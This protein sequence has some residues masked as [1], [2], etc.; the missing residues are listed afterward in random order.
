MRTGCSPGSLDGVTAEHLFHG[1]NTVLPMLLSDMFTICTRFGIVPDAF[2]CGTLVPILKK[3]NLDP[4]I[5]KKYRPITISTTLSKVLEYHILEQCDSHVYSPSQ[6]GFIPNGSTTMAAALAHDV[7]SYSVAS[8]S[9]VY[10]CS[11]DAAGAF[12]ALP[13]SI[14]FHRAIGV[15]PDSCWRVL[16]HW[17]K[18]MYVNI[19][20]GNILSDNIMVKRGTRQGG[21]TSSLLFNLFYQ[22]LI[23]ELQLCNTG[24]KI[25]AENY[26][27]YCYADDLLLSS[28]TVSGLQ[29]LINI[30]NANITRNALT[31]NP[32]KTECLLVGG[33]PF[34]E[35]PQWYMDGAS[36]NIVDK[37]T[38]LGT[39]LGDSKGQGQTTQR[40]QATNRAFITRCQP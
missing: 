34:T 37:I 19:K 32:Q 39:I 16:F 29:K 28:T 24:V 27:V 7:A 12:D 1:L 36:L 25:G 3:S 14:I 15:L 8:G 31:F 23:N 33:N 6:F 11:L 38:Y 26:N 30:A 4:T 13:H 17:Y 20:L 18:N 21:L 35:T 40:I 10:F 2:F 9:T 5:P 22:D